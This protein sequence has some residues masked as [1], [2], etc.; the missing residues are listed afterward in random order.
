MS[1]MSLS[2]LQH[3][4]LLAGHAGCHIFGHS[5]GGLAAVLAEERQ[6]GTFQAMYLYEPVVFSQGQDFPGM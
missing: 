5:A 1:G 2:L 3:S 4:E 6:P